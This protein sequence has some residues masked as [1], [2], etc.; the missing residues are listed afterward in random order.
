MSDDQLVGL[1]LAAMLAAVRVAPPVAAADVV[2]R[3]LAAAVGATDV[4]FLI[5]D[6]S[7]RALIRLG[8]DGTQYSERTR[9]AETAARVSLARSP[10]GRAP[11][12]QTSTLATSCVGIRAQLDAQSGGP[13]SYGDPQ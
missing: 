4:A 10:H 12:T 6:F 2:G 13:S 1:D 9:G 11:R 3:H 7:G 8:H 5:A